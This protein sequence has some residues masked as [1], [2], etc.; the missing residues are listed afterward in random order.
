M[1]E[2]LEEEGSSVEEKVEEESKEKKSWLSKLF[3]W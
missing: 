2:E 1:N 3:G